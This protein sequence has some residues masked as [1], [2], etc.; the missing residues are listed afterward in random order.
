MARPVTTRQM[1][2]SEYADCLQNMTQREAFTQEPLV[3][4]SDRERYNNS[5]YKNQ[6]PAY[7]TKTQ[8][9][10]TS[11]TF[12]HEDRRWVGLDTRPVLDRNNNTN[13][14]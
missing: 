5:V 11:L 6:Y 14:S 7:G 3:T 12:A 13:K 1:S 9:C 8:N 4:P 10:T 2:V